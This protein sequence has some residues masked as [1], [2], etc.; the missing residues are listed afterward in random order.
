MLR[1]AGHD[2][3]VES[4]V[5][6]L[7]RRVQARARAW[8]DE[9]ERRIYR[10][11]GAEGWPVHPLPRPAADQPYGRGR[12]SEAYARACE[13]LRAVVA[14]SYGGGLRRVAGGL[15]ASDWD[16]SAAADA[17]AEDMRAIGQAMATDLVGRAEGAQGTVRVRY[18]A[19]AGRHR[20]GIAA[21]ARIAGRPIPGATAATQWERVTDPGW[22]R[23][24]L[25]GEIRWRTEAVW[26]TIAPAGIR[27]V[28]PDGLAEHRDTRRAQATWL[29]AHQMV[30]GD[31]G[32]PVGLDKLAEGRDRRR[33]AEL[34]ARSAGIAENAEDAGMQPRLLTITVPSRMH[35]TTSAGGRRR[36]NPRY[37]GTTVR[38]AHRWA[39]DGWARWRTALDRRDIDIQWAIGAQP[40]RDGCPHYHAV[41]WARPDDWGEVERLAERY[42]WRCEPD[43]HA[44]VDRRIDIRPCHGGPAGAVAY[45]SRMIAYIARHVDDSPDAPDATAEAEA[46]T[47]WASAHRIRRYRTSETHATVWR[48][49][50]RGD[51]DVAPLGADAVAAQA[52]ARGDR[53]AGRRPDYAEFVRRVRAAGIRPAYRTARGRY[54]DPCHRLVGVQADRV[55]VV[56]SRTWTIQRKSLISQARTVVQQVPRVGW[57]PHQEAAGA[58]LA[59]LLM[60]GTGPP[61]TGPP[62]DP[63][64]PPAANTPVPSPA[65][66]AGGCSVP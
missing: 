7:P 66:S 21:A 34:L 51:V 22:W 26:A 12:A 13:E 31:G 43:A 11:L 5:A 2:H 33:Y 24:H 25:R 3:R 59:R 42:W 8:R 10:S 55:V 38:A 20:A 17:L 19:L 56:P 29:A 4:L 41:V 39:M 16:I 36:P 27:W 60:P 61:A 49:L 48:L 58:V 54:G 18:R 57:R 47:A 46:T 62:A 44:T 52:A 1:P 65:C 50:R 40:H 30:P 9:R 37:D 35:P 23:R 15:A 45:L 53:D 14:L 63:A 64:A 6:R 28:C 32:E